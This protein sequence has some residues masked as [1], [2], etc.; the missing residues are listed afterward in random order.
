MGQVKTINPHHNAQAMRCRLD[1]CE[2]LNDPK[3][4]AEQPLCRYETEERVGG[5]GQAAQ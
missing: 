3:S 5:M 2:S 4:G 1:G